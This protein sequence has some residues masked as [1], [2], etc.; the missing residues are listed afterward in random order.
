MREESGLVSVD[1]GEEEAHGVGGAHYTEGATLGSE[2]PEAMKTPIRNVQKSIAASCRRG[3]FAFM[4]SLPEWVNHVSRLRIGEPDGLVGA[5]R[6]SELDP[7][8]LGG[9]RRESELLRLLLPGSCLDHAEIGPA[10]WFHGAMPKDCYTMV[11]VVACPAEGHSFNFGSRHH[12]RCLGFFAPGE[13]LDATTPEGYRHGTLTIPQADFLKAVESRYPEFP[14]KLLQ[15]G[16]AFFPRENACR[17]MTT[18]LG[19]AAE[20]IRHAPETLACEAARDSLENELH[21]QF[22][23]LILNEGGASSGL[24]HPGMARRYQRLSLVRDYMREH[25]HRRIR[26]VELCEVSGLSRRGLEY[27]FQDLMGVRAKTFLLQSRLWGVRRELLA[28]EP[29]HGLVKRCA[30]NWGFWHL[31]RFAADYR[32]LFGESPSTTV[33]RRA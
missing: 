9:Y 14:E 33:V 16:N 31:G 26:L 24:A 4:P 12:D 13:S 1:S 28:A 15:K 22:F 21:E 32:M 30:L 17:A 6:G 10:M 29:S 25:S 19:A 11:Y 23:D 18:L 20:I 27:L 7:R 2:I 3:Q 8:L 5:I